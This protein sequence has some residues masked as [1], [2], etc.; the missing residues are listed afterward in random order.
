[1]SEDGA[2]SSPEPTSGTITIEPPAPK[3][4]LVES[5]EKMALR[6]KATDNYIYGQRSGNDENPDK[7]VEIYFSEEKQPYVV[8]LLEAHGF[9]HGDV[10][11][12]QGKMGT[13]DKYIVMELEY[14]GMEHV[15]GAYKEV[16]EEV[17]E[18]LG[19][20]KTTTR[21]V[22]ID[23]LYVY[24]KKATEDR[25]TFRKIG[26]DFGIEPSLKDLS[27]EELQKLLK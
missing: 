3:S 10:E 5:L 19:I 22:A 14:R 6:E 7:P 17:K 18:Q 27:L 2:T 24:L 8:D 13:I 4:P 26:M 16:F 21:D 23:K 11:G 25:E 20:D 1:M 12:Y 15:L 9:Y